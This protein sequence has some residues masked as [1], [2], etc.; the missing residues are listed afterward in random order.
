[1]SAA[2]QNARA[3]RAVAREVLDLQHRPNMAAA[4]ALI[5]CL[6]KVAEA[7]ECGEAVTLPD[8]LAVVA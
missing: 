4:S 6:F 1:M 8:A 2:E 5:G 3:L 7:V